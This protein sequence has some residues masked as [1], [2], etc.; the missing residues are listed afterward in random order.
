MTR[1]KNILNYQQV[2]SQEDEQL[3]I[4]RRKLLGERNA[5]SL[6][7]TRIGIA[8]SGGGIRSATINLGLL[9]TLN[10]FKLLKHVDYISTVSGGGYTGAYIQ[11]TTKNIDNLDA[12]FAEE[13]IKY[14]RSRGIYLFP[15]KGI[16]KLWN[17]FL[18]VVGYVISLLMSWVSPAIILLLGFGTYLFVGEII[19]WDYEQINYGWDI[20][21]YYGG[22]TVL[23]LFIFHYLFNIGLNFNLYVSAFFTKLESLTLAVC[24]F[25][26]AVIIILSFR[27]FSSPDWGGLFPLGFMA[28]MLI[29]LGLFTNPNATSFHRYYR[30]QLA[31]TF[32]HFAGY[33]QNVLLQQLFQTDS[34]DKKDY[35][36][37]YPLINTCLNLQSINDTKFQGTK[38]N[39]YFLL[40][41]LYC[42]SKLTG[43]VRTASNTGYSSMTLP[44]ATTISAAAVNPGMGSYSSKI[45]SVFTTIF[46]ARLGYWT[47]NPLK[48]GKTSPIVFWPFY[49]FYELFSMIG[50]NNRMLNISDGGHIENLGVYELLRRKCRL[51]ISV[52][53]GSDPLFVFSDLENLT[54]RARN[55]LG[56]DIRFRPGQDPEDAIRPKPSHGYSKKRF[57]IADLYQIWDKVTKIENGEVQEVIEHYENKK[58]GT[59]IYIKS[60][61]MAPE[62]R[63]MIS[64]DDWLKYGTYK[65]KIYHPNFPH[66]PTSDQFFD[67]IQWESYYQLGQHIGADVLGIDDFVG[68]QD[69]SKERFEITG[70]ELI[71]HFDHELN[72]FSK[73]TISEEEFES[74]QPDME[75]EA[76]IEE[77]EMADLQEE[78]FEET[79]TR[80]VN[81]TELEESEEQVIDKEVKY[82]M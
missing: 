29:V 48:V 79:F 39:D 30:K 8:L 33:H 28:M 80:N 66:E 75:D 12:L 20:A 72:L 57:A 23:T 56:I 34:K 36:A 19:H 21:Y 3:R 59:F 51:I 27:G 22:I 13:H 54:I 42:G 35:L 18:L 2:I 37:P 49:F 41:P 67:P 60:S 78:D 7:D 5:Q 64:K 9:K 62:G 55:E 70:E 31:D 74:L 63:P 11:G 1:H 44:A 40:S 76:L 46:N 71:E 38:T 53:A 69:G 32:L 65:Y 4:R 47:W 16:T 6:D 73:R 61:V 58:I 25:A 14:M 10:K 81:P 26:L 50:T 45:L 17:Q 15:G 68:Y 77:L 43:Y 52:D 82:K 24:A